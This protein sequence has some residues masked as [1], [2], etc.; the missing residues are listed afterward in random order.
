MLALHRDSV[1]IGGTR[2]RLAAVRTWAAKLTT[3]L[4]GDFGLPSSSAFVLFF[5]LFALFMV[6]AINRMERDMDHR[7]QTFLKNVNKYQCRRDYLERNSWVYQCSNG[8][9]T[10]TELGWQLL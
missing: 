3:S 7:H 2:N 8:K 9:F 6:W 5:A 1:A 4:R 10:D